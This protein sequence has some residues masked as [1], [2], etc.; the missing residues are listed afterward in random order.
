VSAEGSGGAGGR[1]QIV[2]SGVGGQGVLFAARLLADAAIRK[3]AGVLT[4]ETH[5]MAQRGGVVVSHLKVGD[6]SSPLVR[7][8]RADGL[9]V[10]SAENL[11]LHR[12]FLSPSGW[13]VVNAPPGSPEAGGAG[14]H[15]V[16][17][18]GLAKGIGDPRAANL[19]LLGFALSRPGAREGG[20]LFCTPAEVE[21]ALRRRLESKGPLLPDALRAVALGMRQGMR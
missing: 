5:G 8:G 12:R 6:F 1:Q 9:I 15:A 21:E 20:L 7:E 17:A 3:G 13:T 2:V 14:V 19:V 11:P 4:S 10:L 18:I 16:D